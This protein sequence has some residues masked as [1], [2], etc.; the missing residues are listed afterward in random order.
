MK[1][2]LDYGTN[3]IMLD[4]NDVGTSFD[5]NVLEG[6]RLERFQVIDKEV[7]DLKI[8]FGGKNK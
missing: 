8:S 6:D 1:I 7:S 5:D 4:L 3:R 2:E